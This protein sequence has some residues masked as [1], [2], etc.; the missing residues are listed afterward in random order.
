MALRIG[1]NPIAWSNDDLHELGG[2]TPLE[3]CLEQA[4]DAGF[5]G[6]ELGYKFP[7][8]AGVLRAVLSRFKLDLVSG[9][10]S[11]GLLQ[12]DVN[13]EWQAIAAHKNLLKALGAGVVIVAE[14]SNG[15]H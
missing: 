8:D 14:T 10:H 3:V 12:H 4:R 7:R 1:T 11:M 13:Q 15:I 5:E 6:V 2:D 9:W